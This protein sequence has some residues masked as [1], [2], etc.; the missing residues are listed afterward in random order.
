QYLMT[1]IVALLVPT[2]AFAKGECQDNVQKFCKDVAGE[3]G[4]LQ[5]AIGSGVPGFGRSSNCTPGRFPLPAW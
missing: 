4:G 1:L 2:A 3:K 5:P